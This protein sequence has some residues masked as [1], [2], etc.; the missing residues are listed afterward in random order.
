[1]NLVRQSYIRV[2]VQDVCVD[3]QDVRVDVQDICVDVQ[4]VGNMV[5]GVDDKLNQANRL[6]SLDPDTV[7]IPH[8]HV[9]APLCSNMCVCRRWTRRVV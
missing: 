3:V 5:Q 9:L 1:M 4:D 7:V 2:D 8:A 6:L